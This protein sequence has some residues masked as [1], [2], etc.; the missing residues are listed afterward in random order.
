[1]DVG[2]VI[3]FGELPEVLGVLVMA[4]CGGLWLLMVSS[5]A[6]PQAGL[7]SPL[8]KASD[9]FAGRPRPP[10]KYASD[11]ASGRHHLSSPIL[12]KSN[13]IQSISSM[14]SV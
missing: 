12:P 9:S 11:P 7:R 5:N 3:S 4:G 8:G 6:H 14:A 2:R 13:F 10:L 1:M